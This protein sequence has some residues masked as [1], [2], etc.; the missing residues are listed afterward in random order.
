MKS[1]ERSVPRPIGKKRLIPPS[2]TAMTAIPETTGSC[3]A[4][5]A[6]VPIPIAMIIDIRKHQVQ[7]PSFVAIKEGS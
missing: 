7:Q 1:C 5:G 6:I 4:D 3:A 2:K